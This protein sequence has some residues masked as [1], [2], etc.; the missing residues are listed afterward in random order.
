MIFVALASANL[1]ESRTLGGAGPGC[2]AVKRN[3][4]GEFEG[5]GW[6]G[7]GASPR[8]CRSSSW[9]RWFSLRKSCSS[10]SCSSVKRRFCQTL[11]ATPCLANLLRITAFLAHS[12]TK[13]TKYT[14]LYMEFYGSSVQN[15]DNKYRHKAVS[16]LYRKMEYLWSPIFLP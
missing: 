6:R 3:G 4:S 11:K 9:R 12:C 13:Y 14:K 15:D 5:C 10:N 1:F 8:S 7:C 16:K 2:A